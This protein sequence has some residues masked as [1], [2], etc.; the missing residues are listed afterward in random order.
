MFEFKKKSAARQAVS[1]GLLSRLLPLLLIGLMT[2]SL[3]SGCAL[4]GGPLQNPL[5]SGSNNSPAG[6]P[7]YD[8]N[9]VTS[10]YER[11]IPAVV[12]IAVV[13][14]PAV[15]P[16]IPFQFNAPQRRGQGSGFFIDGE[17]H[18]LTNYHVIEDAVSVNVILHDGT[19]LPVEIIGTDPRNDVALLKVDTDKAGQIVVLPLAD[20][21]QVHPG[22]MAIALGSPFGLEGSITVGVV[23]GVERSLAGENM[24]AIVNVIQTDAAINPGNS[25]G[26]L[27][28][29]RGE[30]IGI[31]TAIDSEG[32]GIGFAVPSN[33]VKSR[34]PALL[35]GGEIKTPWLGIR[36]MKVDSELASTLNL[37]VEQGVYVIEVLKDSPAHKAGLIGDSNGTTALEPA[38]DAD[39]IASIDGRGVTMVEDILGYLNGLQ[40]GDEVTVTLYRGGGKM[41]VKVVL[42][43]WPDDTLVIEED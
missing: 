5:S 24:R 30:V 16:L 1:K 41:E 17:G 29:S 9:V 14:E 21:D 20:S 26:P 38:G 40:P 7:L 10:L 8:E 25:G 43:A 6:A 39:V 33:M 34:L 13:V 18:L 27:L 19:R 11:T 28:N 12:E 4:A 35:A 31:N 37:P 22:Q 2:I 23:S 36:G 3:M 42:D 32:S 15:N